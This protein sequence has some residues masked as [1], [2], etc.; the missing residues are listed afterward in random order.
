LSSIND[1]IKLATGG[2][3][4]ADG[5]SDWYSRTGNE[6]LAD[7]EARWLRAIDT[8][9][10][11][12]NSDMWRN[13]LGS[14]GYSGSLSDMKSAYWESPITFPPE[15]ANLKL[16]ARFNSGI[17]ITGSGVSQW[18][19]VSGNGNHLKQGTDTNRPSKEAGG[20]ILFDGVD[21]FLKADAFTLAQ[22]ETIYLLGQAVSHLSGDRFFDG[23][24]ASSGEMLLSGTTPQFSIYAGAFAGNNTDLV[25]GADSV[26]SV[27]FNGAL[28]LDQVDNNAPVTG[29]AGTSNMGGFI[30]GAKATPSNYGNIQI[31]E[32]CVFGSA[33][34]AATRTKTIAYLSGVGG[35]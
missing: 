25:I 30:L 35:L 15:L 33:H 13:I 3:S 20:S 28:S 18:D 34:D 26:I 14:A 24:T 27:V 21:N 23:N 11:K 5:L 22:P 9:N 8:Q 6:S 32:I 7:A 17:T 10:G 2:N 4:V 31:K 1:K 19:D 29:N 12:S 16:W